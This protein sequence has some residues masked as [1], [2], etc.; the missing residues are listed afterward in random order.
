MPDRCHE[1]DD[2]SA[3]RDEASLI[4]VHSDQLGIQFRVEESLAETLP[5]LRSADEDGAELPVLFVRRTSDQR[6]RVGV[7]ELVLS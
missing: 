1:E 2:G 6:L 4:G 3:L 5:G 7:V